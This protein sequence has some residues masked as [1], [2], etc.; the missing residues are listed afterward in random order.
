MTSEF[1]IG[2]GINVLERCNSIQGSVQTL[3]LSGETSTLYIDEEDN[4]NF[5]QSPSLFKKSSRIPK[6]SEMRTDES[7]TYLKSN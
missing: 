4:L 5:E 6:I 1:E 7:K 3:R 2:T